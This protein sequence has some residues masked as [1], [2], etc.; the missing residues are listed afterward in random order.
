MNMVTHVTSSRLLLFNYRAIRVG[1]QC[2]CVVRVQAVIDIG[3]AG[4]AVQFCEFVA[5]NGFGR[6]DPLVFPPCLTEIFQF[7]LGV[8]D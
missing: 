6:V 3:A 4:G 2:V 1:G 5:Y 7:V 8:K